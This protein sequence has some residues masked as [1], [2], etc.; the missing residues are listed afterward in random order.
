[1]AVTV[2]E[3]VSRVREYADAR[4]D[5]DDPYISDAA[6]VTW[7]NQENR[8]LIRRL[9]RLRYA[10]GPTSTSFSTSTTISAGVVAIL[11]VT[12]T[13]GTLSCKVP[14]LVDNAQV[15]ATDGRFWTV[16][17]S[18]TGGLTVT[19]GKSGTYTVSY[20]PIPAVLVLSAPGAGQAD[21]VYYPPGWE[22]VLVLGAALR[23]KAKEGAD[24][25]SPLLRQ[26]YQDEWEDIEVEAAMSDQEPVVINQDQI[27]R[28]G[29]AGTNGYQTTLDW[30]FPGA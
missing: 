16:S 29:W 19:V 14:R 30:W 6:I 10:H 20:V 11:S 9:T 5:G 13:Q 22:E 23:A 2:A 1:M 15:T 12:E 24:T 4:D 26:L 8:R 27:Y 25:E 3:L 28:L 7:L 18:A 17:R 21:S